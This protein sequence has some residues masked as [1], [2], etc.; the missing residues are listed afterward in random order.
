M[1]LTLYVSLLI[2]LWRE[3]KEDMSIT[4]SDWRSEVEYVQQGWRW[5]FDTLDELFNFIQ[6][7]LKSVDDIY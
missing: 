4:D 7:H 5:Q 3:E 6:Q 1:S 2:R